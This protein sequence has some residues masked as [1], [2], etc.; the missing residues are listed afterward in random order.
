MYV[1]RKA[2][3]KRLESS[4]RSYGGKRHR[5]FAFSPPEFSP[6]PTAELREESVGGARDT[7]ISSQL[8]PGAG[9]SFAVLFE[10]GSTRPE[11][12][13]LING[14]VTARFGRRTQSPSSPPLTAVGPLPVFTLQSRMCDTKA[15]SSDHAP[16]YGRK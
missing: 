10:G 5:T 13:Q 7:V 14:D 6:F 4:Q 8:E 15:T 16:H 9:R 2:G 1:V 11:R 12:R 3:E